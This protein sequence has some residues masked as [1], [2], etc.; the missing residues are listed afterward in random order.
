MDFEEKQKLKITVN[1]INKNF[2]DIFNGNIGE[3]II[4]ELKENKKRLEEIYEKQNKRC[5]ELYFENGGGADNSEAIELENNLI[6]MKEYIEDA[7]TYISDY[8]NFSDDKNTENEISEHESIVEENENKTDP[9]AGLPEFFGTE[10]QKEGEIIEKIEEPEEDE[11]TVDEIEISEEE[12]IFVENIEEVQEVNEIDK[13]IEEQEEFEAVD[14]IK[15][16]EE[17]NEEYNEINEEIDETIMESENTVGEEVIEE[18][19]GTEN[20]DEMENSL[21]LIFDK[22]L[23]NENKEIAEKIVSKR[24]TNVRSV[25]QASVNTSEALGR[26]LG[27]LKAEEKVNY[28]QHEYEKE[29]KER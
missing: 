15:I 9:F 29:E 7:Q 28:N 2:E 14:E 5:E 6:F 24:G 3:A 13:E 18:F 1:N 25:V 17:E 19:N 4:N 22:N 11:E 20:I 26:K 16:P 27:I 23:S 12:N 10:I 21:Y 8:E